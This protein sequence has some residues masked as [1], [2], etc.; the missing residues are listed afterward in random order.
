[1][2][3]GMLLAAMMPVSLRPALRSLVT[4]VP[5]APTLTEGDGGL[6]AHDNTDAWS[7]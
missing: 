2:H 7:Q 1:M 3:S 4:A 6:T 5:S